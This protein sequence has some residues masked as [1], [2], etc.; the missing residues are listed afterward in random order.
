MSLRSWFANLQV[1]RTFDRRQREWRRSP[2]R[3]RTAWSSFP[4]EVLEVRSLLSSYTAASVSALI[5]D[6]NAANANGGANTITLAANTKFDLTAVNNTTNGANG[7]PVI[8]GTIGP[9]NLTI[10]GTGGDTI[11]RSTA[12]S[13]PFRL[14]DVANGNSLTLENVTLQNGMA[15]GSGDAEEGGAIF[16][17]GALTL[18]GAIVQG[19][20][21]SGGG[22]V[23]LGP[24]AGGG[25]YNTGTLTVSGCTIT[26]NTAYNRTAGQFG[27]GIFNHGI[28]SVTGST[29]SGNRSGYGGGIDNL[30]RLTI[31]GCTFSG[32]GGGAGGGIAHRAL[33]TATLTNCTFSNNSGGNG[34]GMWILTGG[35]ATLTNCTFSNNS[36]HSYGGALDV[37]GSVTLT[38]CTLSLNSASTGGGIWVYPANGGGILNL[39]NTI[40]AGNTASTGPDIDGAAATADHNLV[41]NATGSTGIVNGVNGNIV[42]S[43]YHVINA[44]LGPLQN[45]GGPTQTMA[46]LAGSPAIGQADNAAAPTTDQ[47]G[48]TR[49]DLAGELTDIGAFEV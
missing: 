26:N 47:R 32:N 21:A 8:S 20:R 40:V 24:A 9:D 39:T 3:S 34:G 41:G 30:G 49:R 27:G 37:E 4:A 18:N 36:A 42:G 23:G 19:N 48:V 43:R 35:K 2:R 29:L 11:E 12:A 14:F 7:L 22:W 6:I 46:L 33:F 38:N 31:S 13:R 45:N 17:Q 10:V 15:Q 16:N 44:L 5:A 1:A 25:I 28:L